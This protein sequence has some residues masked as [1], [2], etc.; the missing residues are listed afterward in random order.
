M[1]LGL[2]HKVNP[3]GL[4]MPFHP[5]YT[6]YA[7]CRSFHGLIS[8]FPRS[9]NGR[10]SIFLLFSRITY[11]IP[12]HKVYDPCVVPNIFFKKVVR[13]YGLPK[14]IVFDKDSKFLKFAYNNKFNT[15]TSYFPFELVYG[16][17]P[18]SPLDLLPLPNI[19][20]MLNYDYLSKTH[21]VK[22]FHAKAHS[23]I[24][25]KVEQYCNKVNNLGSLK[26]IKVISSGDGPF[27]VLKEVNDNVYILDMPQT[28]E[29]SHTFH[30][31]DLFAYDI[32]NQELNLRTNSFQE[33][34]LNA[35]LKPLEEESQVRKDDKENMETKS[36]QD[37]MTRGR[38]K[39]WQVVLKEM[40]LLRS[41]E[42]R[43][44]CLAALFVAQGVC[45]DSDHES[46]KHLKGQQK[47]NKIHAKWVE[48]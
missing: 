38:M 18:L 44:A 29:D 34:G 13:F 26:K 19:S 22:D 17:N 47:L 12:F 37:P 25:K 48:F 36:L 14:T 42:K 1:D 40:S 4:Y 2:Y 15:T 41:L 45:A 3:D 20:S 32:D 7:L 28:Y 6:Y 10:D 35:I 11:F 5:P 43:L 21:F 46:L 8:G 16:F 33:G 24:K 23:H 30:V 31:T 27:K 9:K 39:R